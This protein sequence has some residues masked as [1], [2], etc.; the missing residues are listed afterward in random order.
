MKM[1]D[2]IISYIGPACDGQGAILD[3]FAL[4]KIED[5]ERANSFFR[6]HN[7]TRQ[8][9]WIACPRCRYPVEKCSGISVCPDCG[10]NWKLYAQR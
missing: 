5:L 9:E 1:Q 3:G 8:K 10:L 4:A 6:E 7:T 2:L